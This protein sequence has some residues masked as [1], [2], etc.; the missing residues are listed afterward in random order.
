[1]KKIYYLIS[2]CVLVLDLNSQNFT[3]AKREGLWA[4]DY[5]YGIVNDNAGNVYVAGKYEENAN[6]SGTILPNQGNN[7]HDIFLAKYDAAGNLTWVQTG[8]GGLGDYAH[9]V[10]CDG[11]NYVYVAGE[12]EYY[13]SNNVIVFPGSTITL[14]PVGSNDAVALKYD[15]SGNLLWAKSGGGSQD[16]KGTGIACDNAGN[17]YMCG[18]F[19]GTATFGGTTIT[20]AGVQDIFLAKYDAN[21]N[22]QWVQHAGSSGRDEPK[23]IKCDA[24]GNVYVCGFYSNGATFGSQTLNTNSGAYYDAFLAKYSSNG[25][26][27]WVKNDGGNYDDVAWSMTMDNSG[28]IY[29]SGEF[30]ASAFFGSTQLI[31]SGS[32]DVYVACYDANGVVQWAK[33]AG[34][35]L[36]DRARGI[37]CDGTNIYLTGQFGSTAN[38]GSHSLVASDSSDIF[39]ASISNTGNFIGAISVGG[40]PDSVETLG[41]ESGIA[42]CAEPTGEVYATGSL[43][44]GGVFGTTNISKYGRTDIF[45][46]KISQL[47][48]V[49]TYAEHSGTFHAYPNPSNGTV[50]LVLNKQ[51]E[52]DAVLTVFDCYGQTIAIKKELISSEISIDLSEQKSGVYF[53]E[54]KQQEAVSRKK[55][56]IQK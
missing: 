5:G 28:L 44:S 1:M 7:N 50:T 14:T 6:F 36:I 37:G 20:G 29:I 48:N 56:V 49:N 41:Y 38:F 9:A 13:S 46:T 22:F 32:A 11:S 45:I 3:W 42:V 18:Y 40:V 12:I 15:L 10:T 25:T 24:A 35:S 30:N 39:V 23:S 21:G 4:Y 47:S 2:A 53:I 55:I 33:S 54:M 31:T 16:D 26:L 43:L 19:T 8:G 34:G 27:L 17:I 52:K 51:P